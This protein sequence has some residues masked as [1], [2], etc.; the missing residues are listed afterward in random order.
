MAGP[1]QPR[2]QQLGLLARRFGF[3]VLTPAIAAI[4]VATQGYAAVGR[5]RGV[6]ATWL[7]APGARRNGGRRACGPRCEA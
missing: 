7:A 3:D 2:M 1:V 5:S 6:C 4:E